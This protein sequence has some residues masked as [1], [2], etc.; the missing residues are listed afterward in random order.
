MNSTLLACPCRSIASGDTV[1]SYSKKAGTG[2]Y[3]ASSPQVT[4]PAQPVLEQAGPLRRPRVSPQPH[5]VRAVLEQVHLAGHAGGAERERE[6]E[7]VL[8]LYRL[9]GLG[10]EKEGRWN[11]RVDLFVERHLR[12]EVFRR[13]SPQEVLLRAR[14]GHTI[15]HRYHGVCQHEKVGTADGIAVVHAGGRRQM[16]PR[17]E[18]HHPDAPR[19]DPVALRALP[20]VLDGASH[21]VARQR[22][23][24]RMDAVLQHEG[25]HPPLR[26][27]FANLVALV[28]HHTHPVAA[29]G[30]NDHRCACGGARRR[31]V[32]GERHRFRP[33]STLATGP[34]REGLGSRHPGEREQEEQSG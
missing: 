12:H 32:R 23:T 33:L 22:V 3:S 19:V 10:V 15:A 11:L 7:R 27:P 14:M 6:P 16:P 21:V 34:E 5:P 17:R 20:H 2:I 26:K 30:A 24:V 18:T 8:R 28:G 9:V 13:R 4:T 25:R 29:A 1:S 31:K